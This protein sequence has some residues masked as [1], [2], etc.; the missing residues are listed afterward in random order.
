MDDRIMTD[1]PDPEPFY[2]TLLRVA[3]EET[4][5]TP[6]YKAMALFRVAIEEGGSELGLPGVIFLLSSMM[7]GYLG[8]VAQCAPE[9][10]PFGPPPSDDGDDIETGE[11]DLDDVHRNRGNSY[12]H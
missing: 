10:G 3:E 9:I 4:N 12:K 8:I 1:T 2:Q 11:I 7:V 6:R 5:I